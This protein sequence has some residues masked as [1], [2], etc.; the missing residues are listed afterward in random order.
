MKSRMGDERVREQLMA[1]ST[2]R[3]HP[4][5]GMSLTRTWDLLVNAVLHALNILT[6]DSSTFHPKHC[7]L[8]FTYEYHTGWSK[9]T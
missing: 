1:G 9:Q 3:V 2:G 4:A 6:S 8:P 5:S 7:H